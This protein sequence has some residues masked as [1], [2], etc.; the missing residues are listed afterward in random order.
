[1]KAAAVRSPRSP[2][3][4]H[5][6]AKLANALGVS[7]PLPASDALALQ[8]KRSQSAR[9][10]DERSTPEPRS[11]T[12]LSATIR[13]PSSRYLIHV[14]PPKH[15]PHESKLDAESYKAFRR[16]TLVPLHA[17]LQAQLNAISREF[18]LPTAHGLI[19]YLM[20]DSSIGDG[21]DYATGKGP[22][23]SDEVWKWLCLKV[24][25][26]QPIMR[27]VGL[28][29]NSGASS[30]ALG[31]RA[32]PLRKLSTPSQLEQSSKLNGS[33]MHRTPS[34]T[35]PTT[36]TMSPSSPANGQSSPAQNSDSSRSSTNSP[37]ASNDTP[38]TS[39]LEFDSRLLPGLGSPSLI[40]VLAKVE[41][42]IDR[43]VGTWYD[44]WSRSRRELLRRKKK[45][46]ES[47][48]K[49]SLRITIN[50]KKEQTSTSEPSSDAEDGDYARL[51]DSP[52]PDDEL[53]ARISPA[54]RDPLAEVFGSDA[55]TW[56][57]MQ[58]S[59][60]LRRNNGDLALD[61]AALSTPNGDV[62]DSALVGSDSEEVRALW[63]ARNQPKLGPGTP[64]SSRN[65][66]MNGTPQSSRKQAPPPLTLAPRGMTEIE[67][68]VAT[69]TPS[70]Y[71][72]GFDHD[73]SR[74]AYLS[75]DNSIVTFEDEK[76]KEKRVAGIFDDIELDLD[77]SADVS[78]FTLV[79]CSFAYSCGIIRLILTRRVQASSRC[80][81]NSTSL[82]A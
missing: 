17:T 37:T 59:R 75:Q 52:D 82:S 69:P 22:R 54:R 29:F 7:T 61:G 5:R 16:G 51:T 24:A 21:A 25:D 35:P 1:M 45:A 53:T 14:V 42:D 4:P 13:S 10:A 78:V 26:E 46:I 2:L 49:V 9:Q 12:P 74:L 34:P 56:S 48:G 18:Q 76:F 63:N 71:T 81:S 70:P 36:F 38:A 15:L 43:R 72:A 6:L 60:P 79:I 23:I 40:P 19:L 66:S 67:L 50:D 28:G 47:K 33:T 44:A 57:D 77:L 64:Q 20:G 58:S 11:A 68:N 55:D 30:P 31:G 41:F 62:K 32:S 39:S 27:G 73:E 80:V 8:L 3:P 65:G